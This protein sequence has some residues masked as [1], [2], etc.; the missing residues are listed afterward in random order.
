MMMDQLEQ[1]V[2]KLPAEQRAKLA[3]RIISS[4]DE[5]VEIE[6]EWLAEVRRRDADLDTGSVEGIPLEDA[7][8]SIRSRFGW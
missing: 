7:L 8:V 1:E 2:L 6:V 4:L 5:E 3:E